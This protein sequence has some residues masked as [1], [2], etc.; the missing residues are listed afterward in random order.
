MSIIKKN[1]PQIRTCAQCNSNKQLNQFYNSHAYSQEKMPIC[2]ECFHWEC[3]NNSIADTLKKYDIPLLNKVLESC[4]HDLSNYMRMINSMPQY[5]DLTWKDSQL[6]MNK[7]EQEDFYGNI[8]KL[9][10]EEAY[11]LKINLE[12]FGKNSEM[13]LYISTLKSLRETLDLIAKYDWQLKYSKYTTDDEVQQ[14]S[15]WEQ[16]HEGQI[17]NHKVWNVI[18]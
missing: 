5:R 4:D 1:S 8:V 16:N 14:V 13:N 9:L 2:K 12:V 6:E 11:K 7:K 15:I 10:K 17:R 18:K 3:N